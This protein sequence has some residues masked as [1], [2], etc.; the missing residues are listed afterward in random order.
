MIFLLIQEKSRKYKTPVNP[1]VSDS[2]ALN[3]W[4]VG[5]RNK[6]MKADYAQ[7]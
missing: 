3:D 5:H 4:G 2:M 6:L 7:V 1:E